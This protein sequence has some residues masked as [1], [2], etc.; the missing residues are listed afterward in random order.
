MMECKAMYIYQTSTVYQLPQISAGVH[1]SSINACISECPQG[2][3]SLPAKMPIH[4]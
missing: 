3:P 2:A 1:S 4:K